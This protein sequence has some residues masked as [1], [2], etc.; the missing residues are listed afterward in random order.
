MSTA[1]LVAGMHRSGT[2]A[3]TGALS[4]CGVALGS[5]LIPAAEDNPK[6]YWESVDA[7]AIHDE[8]LHA[9]D[10]SWDDVRAL[11]TGWETSDPAIAATA[12]IEELVRRE[13]ANEPLWAIKDPRICRFMP[14]WTSV[15][16]KLGIE[17]VA[18]FVVRRPSEVAASI[19]ARNGWLEPMGELLWMRHV[20]EAESASRHIARCV[21][22]YEEILEDALGSM[23]RAASRLGITL[24][25]H[26]D[27]VE[28][29][30]RDFVS[31]EGRH[32]QHEANINVAD[33]VSS[34]IAEKAYGV[35]AEIAKSNTGWGGVNELAE[36]FHSQPETSS[37]YL[38]A[39]ADS[40]LK[41]RARV[42]ESQIERTKIQSDLY[43]QIQWSEEA[44]GRE[45]ELMADRARVR[46]DLDLAL[47]RNVEQLES[48]T[49]WQEKFSALKFEYDALQLEHDALRHGHEALQ[50]DR[51][52]L[53]R[54]RD[55]IIGSY[56]WQF[57]SPFR[58][59]SARIGV[60]KHRHGWRV[61]F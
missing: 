52:A 1:I 50:Q 34:P 15:L 8:L 48:L 30:L 35:F 26:A 40:A 59:I 7:V 9:L 47:Q 53:Q 36:Q 13:F 51:D 60:L 31:A 16:Q 58:R 37:K 24:P 49:K 32:H 18:L 22:T 42:A 45:Q 12:A 33:S 4:M 27:S 11:P 54:E 43:A 39:V 61:R 19:T 44:V 23:Q 29:Q 55:L 57:T 46:G 28:T 10:R 41:L 25:N 2:S 21:V 38:D 20:F 6:G 5:S 17:V 14:L 3:T 56:S